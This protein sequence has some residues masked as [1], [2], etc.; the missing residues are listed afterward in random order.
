MTSIFLSSRRLGPP[1][2]VTKSISRYSDI[3]VRN[4][5]RPLAPA[6]ISVALSAALIAVRSDVPMVLLVESAG[7]RPAPRLTRLATAGLMLPAGPLLPQEHRSLEIGVRSLVATQLGIDLGYTEQLHTFAEQGRV[8]G[9]RDGERVE[10]ADNDDQPHRVSVGYLALMAP[11]RGHWNARDSAA[12]SDPQR[13]RWV[14][15]YDVLPWEDWRSGRPAIIGELIEPQLQT[16]ANQQFEHAADAPAVARQDQIDLA[17]GLNGAVWD[18]ERTLDRHELLY[19]AGLLCEARR[20]SSN[21][22]N[23]LP[24]DQGV[25]QF[26]PRLGMPLALDHRRML[27]MALGRLR[28]KIKYRP[29]VFDLMAETFTLYELQCTVQ[30]ILGTP[31]HKQNFR[32][33]VATTGLVEDIGEIRVKTGGRPAKLFRFRPHVILERSAPGVR[34]K[35]VRA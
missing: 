3:L 11:E 21:A 31:L 19:E 24:H 9:A 23:G 16:W 13:G 27:A 4:R 29:L 5:G 8:N 10:A 20:D 33:L 18:D 1:S 14:S 12:Q 28:A 22:G 32:R 34:I 6:S 17:F 30:A 26:G 2:G 7:S 25:S 35:A 15:C